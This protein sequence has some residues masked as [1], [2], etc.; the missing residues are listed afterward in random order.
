MKTISKNI[1]NI[2]IITIVSCIS[3]GLGYYTACNVDMADSYSD[4]I[5][6]VSTD[7]KISEDIDT[8]NTDMIDNNEDDP[9]I[10]LKMLQEDVETFKALMEEVKNELFVTET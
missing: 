1:K 5:K 4:A 7:V 2:I 9:L 6:R 10:H 3:F 8:N